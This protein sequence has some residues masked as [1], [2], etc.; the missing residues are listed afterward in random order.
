MTMKKQNANIKDEIFTESPHK[1]QRLCDMN[2][3]TFYVINQL[4]NP[5]QPLFD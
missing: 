3:I 4:R 5:L 1:G 2:Y